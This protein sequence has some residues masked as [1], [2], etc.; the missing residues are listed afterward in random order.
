MRTTRIT[1]LA[2]ALL[3]T[4]TACA[5]GG[6]MNVPAPV[7]DGEPVASVVETCQPVGWVYPTLLAGGAALAGAIS[8][9]ADT[10]DGAVGSRSTVGRA[11][12]AEKWP[13]RDTD[14]AHFAVPAVAAGVLYL[15]ALGNDGC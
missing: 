8:W 2:A 12:P 15:V 4:T 14:A 13:G 7:L 5:S 9:H 3:A 10:G 1:L 6:G 11:T